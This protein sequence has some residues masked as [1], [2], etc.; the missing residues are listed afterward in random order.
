MFFFRRTIIKDKREVN[1]FGNLNQFLKIY[2]KRIKDF[3]D[4]E[5]SLCLYALQWAAAVYFT[6]EVRIVLCY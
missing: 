6:K 2:W 4:Q 3:E 5:M 1:I